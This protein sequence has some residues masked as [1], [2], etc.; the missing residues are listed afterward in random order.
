[1]QAPKS[2]DALREHTEQ[3][4]RFAASDVTVLLGGRVKHMTT[5][6]NEVLR[7][8]FAQVRPGL[9][10]QKSRV[11]TATGAVA[12]RGHEFPTRT[13]HADLGFTICAH[14][15]VFAGAKVD[16]GTR[17][18]LRHLSRMRPDATSAID[19]GCGTGA[20]AAAL[21]KARPGLAIRASD[22]S[23]AAVQ[24]TLA[25]LAA[26]G[27]A[28]NGVAANGVADRVQVVREA[29]LS[30]VPEHSVDLIVCN[31]PFHNGVEVNQ[32]A[33]LALFRAAGR[34]LAPGGEFWAVY[35][36]HLLYRPALT[37]AIGPTVQISRTVKF[38][39]TRST[40]AL[41]GTS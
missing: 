19:L 25:T 3:I 36:S 35:N 37:A 23:R 27:V 40:A 41:P 22:Q 5:T 21:A 13:E 7:R 11:I 17:E 26:N 30:S 4:A 18:L 14:G 31:P 10:R 6:M 12:P 32:S 16:I 38:T 20:L 39:V 24:S 34:A 8:H 28:A 29:A 15:G 33:A 9:A 1:M 2:L